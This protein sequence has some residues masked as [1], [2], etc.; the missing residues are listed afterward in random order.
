MI[1]IHIHIHIYIYIYIM[2]ASLHVGVA[3]H[4][5]GR[6]ESATSYAPRIYT[7]FAT[8]FATF[9]ENLHLDK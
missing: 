9:E 3:P 2:I 8:R 5:E 6:A 4:A 1:C 7:I